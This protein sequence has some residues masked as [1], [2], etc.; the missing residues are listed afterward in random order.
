MRVTRGVL[1]VTRKWQ[2]VVRISHW[3]GSARC[4]TSA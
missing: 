4:S 2:H 1:P 3:R